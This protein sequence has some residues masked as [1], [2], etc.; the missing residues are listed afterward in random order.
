ML[1]FSYLKSINAE[2]IDELFSLYLK[3]PELVD[4]SWRYFFDGLELGASEVS[5]LKNGHAA[6]VIALAPAPRAEASVSGV[7]LAAEARVVE[8]IQTYRERGKWL[9][10]LDPLEPAPSKHAGLQ[11]WSGCVVTSSSRPRPVSRDTVSISSSIATLA[12]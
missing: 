11:G 12:G 3:S 1:K 9:A 5:P 6:P 10:Q 8:L 4:P 7:D 2:Y